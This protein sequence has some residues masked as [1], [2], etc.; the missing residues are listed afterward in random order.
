MTISQG[1]L[2]RTT[3]FLLLAAALLVPALAQARGSAPR[4]D[5]PSVQ[6]AKPGAS[7]VIH[8]G[9][10]PT[11]ARAATDS[12]NIYGGRR[13]DGSND[14]RP[15]GQFQNFILFPEAQGWTGVDLTEKP[16]FWNISTF[17]A[18]NLDPGA[19]NRAYWSGLPAGTPGFLTAPGYGNNWN[20]ILEWR[21]QA[22]PTI[23][24]QVRLTFDFNFDLE[25][26]YDFFVVEYDSAGVWIPL[27]SAYSGSNRDEVSGEFVVKEVFDETAQF[28]PLMYTGPNGIDVR[29]RVRVISDVA[30]SD[31]DGLYPSRGAVQ[32]DNIRVFFNGQ[33]ATA[34]AG[35]DGLATFEDLGIEDDT[36]GWAPVSAA[37][38]GD[39]AKVLIQLR[40]IDPCRQNLSP[41]LAFIDDGT[42]PANAPNQTTGGST[43]P[44]WD[45]GVIGGYVV[46]YTGGISDL[47]DVPLTNEWWSP[48]IL[49]DDPNST[50]DD[51]LEGGA[52]VRFTVWQHLPLDN[53]MFWVW[54]VRSK[55]VGGEWSPW[56]D[57]GF[58][59]YGDGGGTYLNTELV[60]T[61]LLEPDPEAVQIALGV[62]DLAASFG[63]TGNDATPSP[64]FDNVS[65]WRYQ[66]PGPAFSVREID[67]FQDGFPNS[68]EIDTGDLSLLSVRMDAALDI[69]GLGD[70]IVPGD[71]I[72]VDVT[73]AIPGT[74]LAGMPSMKWVLDANPLFDGVRQMPAGA[75]NLG[76]DDRG[77]NQW[78][79]TVS[80]DSARTTNGTAVPD[81]YFF[82]LPNDGP[83]ARD[84]AHQS[85]E[86]AMFFP[87][88]VIR[89]F[90]EATDTGGN[91]ASVPADTTGFLGDVLAYARPFTVKALPT[92]TDLAGSQ[93]SILVWNDFGSRGNENDFI[94]SFSQLGMFEGQDFDTY[95]TRGPSSLVSNGL[96]SD[97]AG[98][99]NPNQLNGYRTILYLAGDLESGLMSD[100][101]NENGND[102]GADTE[103]LSQWT[104]L[105][106]D[107][108]II[109]FGDE[110]A[111][112]MATSGAANGAYLSSVM[113]VSVNDNDLRDDL[114]GLSTPIVRPVTGGPFAL[115][116]EILAYGGCLELNRFDSSSSSSCS[117]SA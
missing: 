52:L 29:L 113:G 28:T 100:G 9:P 56:R 66:S 39:F 19:G 80:G 4:S 73:P 38:A 20:D 85:D 1:H 11:L 96:G 10:A 42:P 107:R 40:D 115:S 36:E 8:G 91:L 109:H 105:S 84:A 57:R 68:G 13:R 12:F 81:R 60:V 108:N 87:G 92:I 67:L 76:P 23:N 89:Y 104:G 82:D 18:E 46:N 27:G 71:S 62:N 34:V 59:Y 47:G 106:G 54:H 45:Y 3:L 37:Y 48:E 88:D 43:S 63:F 33:P 103:V 90:I 116:T 26:G 31:E 35:G 72:V 24:T 69:N 114:F 110:L 77:W 55:S 75:T 83:A 86:P 14:R 44:N 117:P 65:F 79:G 64:A 16:V 74:Q 15:E 70:A 99:A 17:N 32:I 22:N 111:S 95:T 50:E 61:D 41:M 93:P 2:P 102:K 21:G 94:G 6:I 25:P 78:F 58:V 98:G 7:N 5:G 51:G 49:W 101:S 30:Y 53:G 112:F 97:G